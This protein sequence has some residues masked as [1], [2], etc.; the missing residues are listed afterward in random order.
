MNKERLIKVL[1]LI[2]KNRERQGEICE[3]KGDKLQA[4]KYLGAE[5]ELICIINI[6]KYDELFEKVEKIYSE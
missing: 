5:I 3:E 6:I 4:M 2:K 1:E